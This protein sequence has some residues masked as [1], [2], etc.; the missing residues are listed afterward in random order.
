MHVGGGGSRV[1]FAARATHRR[2]YV[3]VDQAGLPANDRAPAR[4]ALP[5][6]AVLGAGGGRL[7]RVRVVCARSYRETHIVKERPRSGHACGIVSSS[8]SPVA[9]PQRTGYGGRIF[10][11]SSCPTATHGN[12]PVH[13]LSNAKIYSFYNNGR[14]SQLLANRLAIGAAVARAKRPPKQNAPPLPAPRQ[15][16]GPPAAARP[17]P[18]GA[19]RRAAARLARAR[20]R[21]PRVPA[22]AHAGCLR[23]LHEPERIWPGP[24]PVPR[25]QHGDEAAGQWQHQQHAGAPLR[26]AHLPALARGLRLA[27]GRRGAAARKKQPLGA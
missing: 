10:A 26:A 2:V 21:W 19:A 11:R 6:R 7:T 4:A 24:W 8:T 15:H 14:Y 22:Q 18:L 13:L 20:L 12:G 3:R 1:L 9:L 17:R 5:L 23:L 25:Q 27:A 16:A